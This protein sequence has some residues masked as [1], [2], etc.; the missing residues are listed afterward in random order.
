MLAAAESKLDEANAQAIVRMEATPLSQILHASIIVMQ[1]DGENDGDFKERR[2]ALIR[3]RTQQW[4][5]RWGYGH[6]LTEVV[7]MQFGMCGD[8]RKDPGM[9][10]CGSWLYAMPPGTVHFDHIIPQ[11]KGGTND[12]LNIQALCHAC[13]TSAGDRIPDT[14]H[15]PV[16]HPALLDEEDGE[17]EE[18][19]P[20]PVR[21]C[22]ECDEVMVRE[23][24][25]GYGLGDQ[26]KWY[27]RDCGA[28]RAGGE[29]PDSEL[30]PYPFD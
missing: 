8:P 11:S 20:L 6:R 2:G 27:C 13:N 15:V 10:G 14:P 19:D 24:W 21:E 29:K 17:E 16:G 7:A 9:K 4:E 23:H 12:I 26:Y 3:R 30:F 1:R 25:T 22:P 18:L 28:E 5:R